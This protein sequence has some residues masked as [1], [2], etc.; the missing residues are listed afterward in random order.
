MNT[1]K[2]K[3]ILVYD[4]ETD[5]LDTSIAKVKWFGAYSYLDDKYYLIPFKK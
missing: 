4:I 5:S 1:L 3:P 2:N